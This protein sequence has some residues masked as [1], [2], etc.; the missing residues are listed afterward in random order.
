LVCNSTEQGVQTHSAG[1]REKYGNA[2]KNYNE[3]T[4]DINFVLFGDKQTNIE[5][6]RLG[7]A[8]RFLE[9]VYKLSPYTLNVFDE[10]NKEKEM[11]QID[12]VRLRVMCSLPMKDDTPLMNWQL[13]EDIN[14]NFVSRH[15][16]YDMKKNQPKRLISL[17]EHSFVGL[18]NGLEENKEEKQMVW[19]KFLDSDK[20]ANGEYRQYRLD[21]IG[22]SP[23]T[24]LMFFG[25]G[26]YAAKVSNDYTIYL[27]KMTVH[28]H[29][30]N[31]RQITDIGRM[32]KGTES[33]PGLMEIYYGKKE[34]T[35]HG[36]IPYLIYPYHEKVVTSYDTNLHVNLMENENE[37]ENEKKEKNESVELAC[38]IQFGSDG[39]T[40]A[41]PDNTHV[42]AFNVN[43]DSVSMAYRAVFGKS[44]ESI[45]NIDTSLMHPQLRSLVAMG[46]LIKDIDTMCGAFVNPEQIFP[47]LHHYLE[48]RIS[49]L[50]THGRDT[51]S[52][53]LKILSLG[54]T[55]PEAFFR[56]RL[57]FRFL[58]GDTFHGIVD[59][60][61]RLTGLCYCWVGLI[62]ELNCNELINSHKRLLEG[63]PSYGVM[64][65]PSMV[66]LVAC[67]NG[68]ATIE[69]I[70]ITKTMI[71]DIVR[72]SVD[73]QLEYGL[74]E[75]LSIQS[76][77][78]DILGNF[79]K[80]YPFTEK[81]DDPFKDDIERTLEAETE[82]MESRKKG[83]VK[84]RKKDNADVP[85]NALDNF[86]RRDDAFKLMYKYLLSLLWNSDHK[87]VMN[88]WRNTAR[89]IDSMDVL[90][91]ILW[92]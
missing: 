88:L 91:C 5:K 46:C 72:Y 2:F 7:M 44:L 64:S 80:G 52:E 21:M 77:V 89:Y 42:N 14:K 15:P 68:S 30:F 47:C 35:S 71:K 29:G 85:E 50:I 57:M 40:I 92:K 79:K 22:I 62:P 27:P 51:S 28:L 20:I 1:V 39:D 53:T 19:T 18:L 86:A 63:K 69:K 12:L 31:Q 58:L 8:K 13:T 83:P 33:K 49:D 74:G 45:Y 59:G 81:F 43:Y 4:K 23:T 82:K 38:T 76:V 78:L 90:A 9:A 84:K 26:C 25:F 24:L 48:K 67:T 73:T 66:G 17:K 36:T 87:E 34:S 60:I 70:P 11:E 75:T 3:L 61:S 37:N 56:I 41:I 10:N 16:R 54:R 6:Y 55:V 32:M 65:S